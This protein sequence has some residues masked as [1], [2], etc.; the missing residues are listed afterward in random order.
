MHYTDIL[1][2]RMICTGWD[3]L[4]VTA[5]EIFYH[6]LRWSKRRS[7]AENIG[8]KRDDKPFRAAFEPRF[9]SRG[10]IFLSLGPVGVS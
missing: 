2:K 7:E 1:A 9:V 10:Y 6:P 5:E 4:A 8:L 3:D